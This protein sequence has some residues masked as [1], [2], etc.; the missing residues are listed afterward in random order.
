MK[1]WP[2]SGGWRL[3]GAVLVAMVFLW[4][5]RPASS[6]ACSTLQ[7][8]TWAHDATPLSGV[9]IEIWA[10]DESYHAIQYSDAA[11]FYAFTN[12]PAKYYGVEA[13]SIVGYR[14]TNNVQTICGQTN[15]IDFHFPPGGSVSGQVVDWF[16][17][18][19]SNA[20]VN[21]YGDGFGFYSTNTDSNGYFFFPAAC[22]GTQNL[23]AARDAD[24]SAV[25]PV[26]VVA[27]QTTSNVQLRLQ[28]YWEPRV[29][30]CY[31]MGPPSS[32]AVNQGEM[33][34]DSTHKS[35]AVTFSPSNSSWSIL[36]NSFQF[37]L[38]GVA[39]PPDTLLI[40]Q[41]GG[42]GAA[43]IRYTATNHVDL[44]GSHEVEIAVEDNQGHG[45]YYAFTFTGIPAPYYQYAIAVT[46][47]FSP[48]YDFKF[49]DARFRCA[50]APST[51]LSISVVTI[52][53]YYGILYDVGG[54]IWEGV[55]TGQ[56]LPSD[57]YTFTFVGTD[58]GHRYEDGS[59]GSFPSTSVVVVADND[60]P[61]IT[62]TTPSPT[63]VQGYVQGLL[64]DPNGLSQLRAKLS[65]DADWSTLPAATGSWTFATYL[66]EGNNTILVQ[67]EDAIG[68]AAQASKTVLLDSVAP[69]VVFNQPPEEGTNK[70]C[71]S[72]SA[73]LADA[74]TGISLN[75]SCLYLDEVLLAT[76]NFSWN[77]SS[78]SG[79]LP[80]LTP[81][82]HTLRLEARDQAGNIGT[83]TWS[84]RTALQP[85]EIL[86][87]APAPGSTHT[88]FSLVVTVTAEDW[89]CEG[90]ES[91]ALWLDGEEVEPVFDAEAGVLVFTNRACVFPGEHNLTVAITDKLSNT[92]T[93]SWTFIQQPEEQFTGVLY[94]VPSARVWE[95]YYNSWIVLRLGPLSGHGTADWMQMART[96]LTGL[97]DSPPAIANPW[98]YICDSYPAWNCYQIYN[99][100]RCFNF[101][102]ADCLDAT[103][104]PDEP[105]QW[106]N[107]E[108]WPG[109]GPRE[110][111]QAS[112]AYYYAYVDT[113]A[114][115]G[116]HLPVFFRNTFDT[117]ATQAVLRASWSAWWF[118]FSGF[119]PVNSYA[120]SQ[121]G[122]MSEMFMVPKG[123]VNSNG[124]LRLTVRRHANWPT[125]PLSVGLADPIFTLPGPRIETLY[126]AEGS[127][128]EG[129]MLVT[130]GAQFKDDSAYGTEYAIDP[131]SIHLTFA[132]QPV[133]ATY[134]AATR[135]ITAEVCPEQSGEYEVTLAVKNRMKVE[136]T[137]TWRFQYVFYGYL[138]QALRY[139]GADYNVYAR[140]SQNLTPD[141]EHG[142]PWAILHANG[143]PTV[144]GLNIIKRAGGPGGTYRDYLVA[145]DTLKREIIQAAYRAA[146]YRSYSEP[147]NP[148]GQNILD[149]L[150]LVK[151][152]D[153]GEFL[154][155]LGTLIG[156]DLSPLPMSSPTMK[157]AL[158]AAMV[159]KDSPAEV[160]ATYED[161]MGMIQTAVA[162]AQTV[163]EQF[164]RME[165]MSG[166]L[167]KFSQTAER[168]N[169]KLK[170]LEGKINTVAGIADFVGQTAALT[171]EVWRQIFTAYWQAALVEDFRSSLLRLEPLMR[172]T[173]PEVAAAIREL[174]YFSPEQLYDEIAQT[175]A[176][177][178]VDQTTDL[179][180]DLLKDA[181]Q[182]NPYALAVV[183]GIELF[184]TLTSWTNWDDIKA[185]GHHG[186]YVG[187]VVSAAWKSRKDLWTDFDNTA[188]VSV[189][190]LN[191]AALA[192]QIQMAASIHLWDDCRNIAQSLKD[193]DD[194]LDI[195]TLFGTSF[196]EWTGMD[197]FTTDYGAMITRWQE[198]IDEAAARLAQVVPDGPLTNPDSNADVEFLLGV[199]QASPL[200]GPTAFLQAEV[201]SPICVLITDPQG[202]RVGTDGEGH[203]TNEI[204]GATYSGP[205]AEPLLF[206][207]PQP[208]NGSYRFAAF[209]VG[210]GDYHV[211]FSTLNTNGVE[212]SSH[213]FT[214]SVFL[215][216]SLMEGALL[217][218]GDVMPLPSPPLAI[219]NVQLLPESS[220]VRIH[221]A[222][223]VPAYR[224]ID[225]GT[226]EACAD[227]V[228]TMPGMGTN[229]S[230][231]LEGLNPTQNYCFIISA[232]D[233]LRRTTHTAVAT[234]RL[235][236]L[237]DQQPPAVPSGLV[238]QCDSEGWALLYWNENTEPDLAGYRRVTILPD[239]TP[240]TR[241]PLQPYPGYTFFLGPTTGLT[242]AVL[243]EDQAGNTS[244]LSPAVS[245]SL[246]ERT[247]PGDWDCDGLPDE[248]ET[249]GGLNP[250]A[251]DAALDPDGDGLAN[252]NEYAQST[253]PREADTDGD[254]LSDGSEVYTHLTDP[255]RFDTDGDGLSDRVEGLV[256]QT[257][258][259]DS[260]SDDDGMNDGDEIRAGSDPKDDTDVFEVSHVDLSGPPAVRI[261]WPSVTNRSYRVFQTTN[262]VAPWTRVWTVGG[263]G[264]F[265]GYTN[266]AGLTA[267]LFIR[268]EAFQP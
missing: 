59:F 251:P 98:N 150:H 125:T 168:A 183:K 50:P 66:A 104:D 216:E 94:D 217:A 83:G 239:A 65:T 187:D 122:W 97:Q 79:P 72:F 162:G 54:G 53:G 123:A 218:D 58:Q 19:A 148:V 28:T 140:F 92:T 163:K 74:G 69:T 30:Y 88:R 268:I 70:C 214:G 34:A 151:E 142:L 245:L 243:A 202:R 253:A 39:P 227:A 61:S 133:R 173:H 124:E 233:A 186:S 255:T 184:Y 154:Y 229:H 160:P 223:T 219:A 96:W 128:V 136:T 198:E 234:F 55:F 231:L 194:T 42:V 67:A 144:T 190:E 31:P 262:L 165:S 89:S 87:L 107:G 45:R 80:R 206:Q 120:T 248:W 51:N 215:G 64:Q 213:T 27:G 129:V 32:F 242:F 174:V 161:V 244:A 138:W 115:P 197:L 185:A 157:E 84:F 110:E 199:V 20:T 201:L 179:L 76:N 14:W 127:L 10:N 95:S 49:D 1:G 205:D 256:Y 263:D 40:T 170:L 236:D 210:T 102:S 81:G 109:R 47:V 111:E 100:C 257:D 56:Q 118:G 159:S 220:S 15:V 147:F 211:I 93:R 121:G 46:P 131:A 172:G 6:L 7:G 106:V 18:G 145:S 48:N 41:P 258:P 43:T 164:E 254:G 44:W 117:T 12:I 169:G 13:Q 204:P 86:S 180:V 9:R 11:G 192:A 209:A 91:G 33:Y 181:L 259:R 116:T 178:V 221:W 232:D 5:G 17:R 3:Q 99:H 63:H 167:A 238:G 119:Y 139:Q 155:I 252:S 195:G 166:K 78:W 267:P 203:T 113:N 68:N 191:A 24:E 57:A 101:H 114:F 196:L 2:Q 261:W 240:D 90:L 4:S 71:L 149:W 250:L 193:F 8:T 112:A 77:G 23:Y 225:Y 130:I 171:D 137:R 226:T 141:E 153:S 247:C 176:Q 189:E 37:L 26:V 230:A 222:T 260:D 228:W 21:F 156:A 22:A 105:H 73:Q 85:P 235:Q 224:R 266:Q 36:T 212:Q 207:L 25:L 75:S 108:Y 175:I 135:T 103:T 158:T 16:S 241:G 35:L 143:T 177:A 134:Q 82:P 52:G 126:P 146:C 246:N 237:Q 200:Y 188:R 208:T 182:S 29:T 264:T 152:A 265:L 60:P 132:G 249:E 62:I 38:D